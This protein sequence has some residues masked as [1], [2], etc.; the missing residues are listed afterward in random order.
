MSIDLDAAFEEWINEEVPVAGRALKLHE[1]PEAKFEGWLR[2]FEDLREE[3]QTEKEFEDHIFQLYLFTKPKNLKNVFR[4]YICELLKEDG[5]S[6]R[7]IAKYTGLSKSAVHRL[8][9]FLDKKL[10]KTVED[11]AFRYDVSVRTVR[12]ILKKPE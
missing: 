11:F 5:L 10:K 4:A 6:E 12:R 2:K 9:G 1:D 8:L 7:G 3:G